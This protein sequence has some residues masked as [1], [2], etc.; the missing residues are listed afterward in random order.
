MSTRILSVFNLL[1][2]V[3]F[4]VLLLG[5]AVLAQPLPDVIWD[6]SGNANTGQALQWFEEMGVTKLI[7]FYGPDMD[8][9]QRLAGTS[10]K[11]I[12]DFMH[13]QT[14]H[15]GTSLKWSVKMLSSTG[16]LTCEA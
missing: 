12:N 3:G 9:D 7:V 15:E 6:R 16:V 14:L 2:R 11:V 13:T 5:G 1:K 8:Y 4:A 10:F